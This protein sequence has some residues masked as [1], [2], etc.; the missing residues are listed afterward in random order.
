MENILTTVG[1]C[2]YEPICQ[3]LIKT[4]QFCYCFKEKK[5]HYFEKGEKQIRKQKEIKRI[6]MQKT[7]KKI[8][9]RSKDLFEKG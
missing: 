9:L 4:T 3:L 7:V 2:G 6:F 1:S 8:L 5:M